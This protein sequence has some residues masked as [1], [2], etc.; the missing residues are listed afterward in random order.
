MK[1]EE[2]FGGSPRDIA[3]IDAAAQIM[4]AYISSGSGR[5]CVRPDNYS[6]QLSVSG[7]SSGAGFADI[8]F[9]GEYD[10]YDASLYPV[11]AIGNDETDEEKGDVFCL[12]L[13]LYRLYRNA[14]ADPEEAQILLNGIEKY[15]SFPFVIPKRSENTS[16]A[17]A[18]INRLISA[19]TELNVNIRPLMSECMEVLTAFKE[20]ICTVH[21]VEKATLK[22]I[23]DIS[24]P[25]RSLVTVWKSA[26]EY[27]R[28]TVRYYP[29]NADEELSI[30]YRAHD[31]QEFTVF[32]ISDKL[33]STEG[34]PVPQISERLSLG[35]DLGTWT[36]SV[37]Y[38]DENGRACDI[39]ADGDAVIPTL[40]AY[41]ERDKCV[42]G[43][44]AAE[45]SEKYPF[46]C[47][48]RFKR[49]LQSEE[50]YTLTAVNGDIVEESGFEITVR[51]LG[52]LYRLCREKFGGRLDKA[53][54]TLTVPACYDAGIKTTILTAAKKV[55]FT[56]EL[57]SE[58][59]AAAFF[60]GVSYER[61]SSVLVLD[62][63]GGTSDICLLECAAGDTLLPDIRSVYVGGIGELGG[64]DLTD[65]VARR[66]I[67]EGT[68]RKYGLEM[69][70]IAASGLSAERYS[71][72]MKR[73]LNEAERVKKALSGS[74]SEVFSADLYYPETAS[75]SK[76]EIV[77]KR[78][79]YESLIKDKLR[80]IEKQ[81]KLVL[82]SKNKSPGDISDLILTGGVSLTP[83]VRR[84]A[85]GLFADTGC[86]LRF[87]DH[88]SA[89]SRGA[90]VYS[91]EFS[92]KSSRQQ[93]LTQTNFDIGTVSAAP[94]SGTELFRCLIGSGSRFEGKPLSSEFECRL[95][96]KEKLEET[97][98]MT[99]YRRPPEYS[100]VQSPLDAD[101]GDHIIPI[102]S[103]LVHGFPEGF[104]TENS[105]AVFCVSIDPRECISAF[106]RFYNSTSTKS[107]V[108]QR[109]LA[110]VMPAVF[111]PLG[112]D[113]EYEL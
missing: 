92:V 28:G 11:P 100:E 71:D 108:P 44:Q 60:F 34:R 111:V 105:S 47:A 66:M 112:G 45:I 46:A 33:V 48:D 91:N 39:T 87:T 8:T 5:G 99:L 74:D 42:F 26:P 37:S 59:E 16:E 55:G 76:T 41:L 12:G 102:G 75:F 14:D 67:C 53:C 35:I 29:V 17:G 58:P 36:S 86:T 81:I 20:S 72:N 80:L 84:M 54:I 10:G 15:D 4:Y 106:V 64:T 51:Y 98:K 57:L 13:M 73:I 9:C 27:V 107:G 40:T 96:E 32:V 50:K 78:A 52:F 49:R 22:S 24:V 89:V 85:E 7:E 79:H 43:K 97:V 1:L 82:A 88:R 94:F 18:L 110:G 3:V 21:I 77:C 19:M 6:A 38:I 83:A 30:P 56:P 70:D 69:T 68:A 109:Q 31:G 113:K 25:L 65:I 93:L 103:L 95:T 2:W 23:K 63:G 61:A 62:I 90:A 101:G 104:K